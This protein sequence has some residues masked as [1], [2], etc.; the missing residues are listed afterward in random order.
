[1]GTPG[2]G[3]SGSE[4]V[5]FRQS[6]L[7]SRSGQGRGEGRGEARVDRRQCSF[8]WSKGPRRRCPHV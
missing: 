3:L 4:V 5:R 8:P 6:V 7:V 2:S 1:M